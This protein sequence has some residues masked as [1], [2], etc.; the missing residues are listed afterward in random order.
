MSLDTFN[1]TATTYVS[2]I[3][4]NSDE[5]DSEEE[6]DDED[7]ASDFM[8]AIKVWVPIALTLGLVIL[9]CF[10][11]IR[12]KARRRQQRE[13]GTSDPMRAVSGGVAMSELPDHNALHHNVL[14]S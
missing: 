3:H 10:A 6:E 9:I 14:I 4:D 8:D 11:T 7:D 1:W 13:G 2:I 5:D 12:A